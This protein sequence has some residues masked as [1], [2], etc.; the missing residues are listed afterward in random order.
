[1]EER[2]EGDGTGRVLDPG[3]V[4]QVDQVVADFRDLT[5]VLVGIHKRTAHLVLGTDP[6][7]SGVQEEI[8]DLQTR[9]YEAMDE[10][11]GDGG[12]PNMVFSYVMFLIDI[13]AAYERRQENLGAILEQ[14]AG[15]LR[16]AADVLKSPGGNNGGNS[17]GGDG[18][19]GDRQAP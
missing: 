12:D 5:G 9:L 17:G 1:M 7:D 2:I 14:T 4:A 10:A 18:A 15:S 11:F 16:Q 8:A 19:G 6:G 13:V 3:E